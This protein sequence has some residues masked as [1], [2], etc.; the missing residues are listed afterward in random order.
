MEKVLDFTITYIACFA[1]V[2]LSI[3]VSSLYFDM[4]LSEEIS[5]IRPYIFALV[6]AI[7]MTVLR[8]FEEKE[9]L[10]GTSIT[11]SKRCILKSFKNIMD[12]KEK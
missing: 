4:S 3:L 5:S 11:R 8:K 7:L 10:D 6:L 12:Y 2:I 1:G 9:W